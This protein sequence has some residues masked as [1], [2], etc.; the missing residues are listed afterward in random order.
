MFLKCGNKTNTR[1]AAEVKKKKPGRCQRAETA[2]MAAATAEHHRYK[3]NLDEK[4][5]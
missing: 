4:I 5:K 2:V 1:A 3:V